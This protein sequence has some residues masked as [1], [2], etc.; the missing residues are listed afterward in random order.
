MVPVSSMSPRSPNR[1]RSARTVASST[2]WCWISRRVKSMICAS[3]AGTSRVCLSRIAEMVDSGTSWR[4][5]LPVCAPHPYPAPA[6]L[7]QVEVEERPAAHVEDGGLL[8][9]D[10][11]P[12]AHLGDQVGEVVEQLGRAM[13]HGTV[14]GRAPTSGAGGA[15]RTA[16]GAPRLVQGP[17]LWC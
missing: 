13:P 12:R 4:R 10:S 11:G 2:R 6:A 17:H 5:A 1:C 14:R 9:D 7:K 3:S 16:G 8:L 15:V